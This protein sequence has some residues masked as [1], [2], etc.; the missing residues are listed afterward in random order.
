MTLIIIAL[1][2]NAA[3]AVEDGTV[4]TLLSNPAGVALVV[5]FVLSA[6]WMGLFIVP[7]QAAIQRRAPEAQRSRIMAAGNMLNAGAAVLGSLSVAVVTLTALTATNAFF[8]VA[9]LQ[10]AIAIY[11]FRRR[12]MVKAGLYDEA[13]L[14]KNL[15]KEA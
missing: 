10:F 8:I 13:L 5:S 3:S 9:T 7:L 11:M 1:S 15:A 2:D 4:S 12:K 14:E 6:I